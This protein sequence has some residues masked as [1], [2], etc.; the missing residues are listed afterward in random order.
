MVKHYTAE[1]VIV[2]IEADMDAGREVSAE[3]LHSRT[4]LF[5]DDAQ[6]VL[7]LRDD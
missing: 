1:D 6:L 5:A 3:E 4:A 2:E 7:S